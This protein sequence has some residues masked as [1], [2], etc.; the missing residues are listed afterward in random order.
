LS[1]CSRRELLALLTAA[2]GLRAAE[3]PSPIRR[4]LDR[5]YNFDFAGANRILDARIRELPE[6]PIAYT[7]RAASLLFQELDRL[8]ILES[9]FLADDE[10]ITEKKKLKSDPKV[11][12][13][14]YEFI[15]MA[16][17]RAL[18][19]LATEPDD[20]YS[21]FTMCISAG[22]VTDYVGLVERR[23]LGSLQ[24]FKESQTYAVKLLRLDPTFTDA[25]MTKGLAEYVLGSVPFFVRWFVKFE[26][27]EGR[28]DVAETNLKKVIASGRY[29]GPFAKI[30]L[31][32]IYLREKRPQDCE[33][34]LAELAR[35]YPENPLFRK[36]LGRIR[37]LGNSVR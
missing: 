32:I 9:E 27:A 23:Q 2:A 5:M 35:D 30:L 6:D 7:F 3:T 22:L 36:E 20:T 25:Y 18:H 13:E 28:K 17:R 8:G 24:H 16:R 14:F 10:R 26:E 21:L 29:L 37:A 1:A 34:L 4:A 19:R 11:R 31:S 12:R 33:R 15:E